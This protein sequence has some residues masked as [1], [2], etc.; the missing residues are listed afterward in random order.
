M[1]RLLT[2][3]VP[4]K[5]VLIPT[6]AVVVAVAAAIASYP[7]G[8][9]AVADAR[10]WG[11]K[12]HADNQQVVLALLDED[13]SA[14]AA[15][16]G[17][18]SF[19][20]VV[21]LPAVDVTIDVKD[22]GAGDLGRTRE[23]LAALNAE[24]AQAAAEVTGARRQ[25]I[26]GL[27]TTDVDGVIDLDEIA[28]VKVGKRS[29]AWRCLTQAL[30]FEARGESLVGQVAVAEVILNRVDSPAYPN[31]VCA[32]V[33]QGQQQ[34]NGCQFSFFC[35]GKAERIGDRGAY[36]ELGKVA[37]VM[38]EGKPRILTGDATHYHAA[39]VKPRWAK[40]LVRTARIGDHI[41]YRQPLQL[42]KN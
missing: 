34:Q 31:S 33:H 7:F 18:E 10:N 35:D 32:V 25:R 20:R 15:F 36:E 28:H 27:L 30:Y 17:T 12:L 42:S 40:R 4:A 24:D 14:F 16:S 38:L 5:G 37:W 26:T 11:E 23:T 3:F 6:V 8:N 41:F 19:R 2:P 9:V 29:K 21:G 13:R 1:R 22:D 39:T